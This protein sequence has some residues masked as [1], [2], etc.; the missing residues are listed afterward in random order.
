[1]GAQRK[2]PLIMSGREM[3]VFTNMLKILRLS[4]DW[5]KALTHRV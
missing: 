1:M 3:E 2:E 5:W 4:C